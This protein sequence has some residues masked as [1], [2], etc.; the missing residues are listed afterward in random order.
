MS[1]RYAVTLSY[2]MIVGLVDIATDYDG[3]DSPRWDGRTVVALSE[4]KELVALPAVRSSKESKKERVARFKK[5]RLTKKGQ[6][7][8]QMAQFEYKSA[9][10]FLAARAA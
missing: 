3:E 5:A 8:L 7:Y 2:A 9:E 6:A 1:T 10:E 4:R